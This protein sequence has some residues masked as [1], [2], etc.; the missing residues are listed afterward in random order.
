MLASPASRA[1]LPASCCSVHVSSTSR[2]S[3]VSTESRSRL[4]ARQSARQSATFVPS[5]RPAAARSLAASGLRCGARACAEASSTSSACRTSSAARASTTSVSRLQSW[6]W[7][8]ADRNP[9]VPDGACSTRRIGSGSV[10]ACVGS[11]PLSQCWHSSVVSA[12]VH[13]GLA[14]AA[15]LHLEC[16][17][18]PQSRCAAID[19]QQPA[20]PL[21]RSTLPG[22]PQAISLPTILSGRRRRTDIGEDTGGLP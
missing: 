1:A 6:P 12:G 13:A 21:R 8:R 2:T 5:P 17:V 20:G 16:F 15:S 10:Q 7:F 19:P 14:C 11:L 4:R 18:A 9:C 22:L 3:F